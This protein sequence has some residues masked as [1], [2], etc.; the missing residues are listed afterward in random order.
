MAEDG[1]TDHLNDDIGKVEHFADEVPERIGIMSTA[2]L[3]E[4]SIGWCIG[5]A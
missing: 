5:L 2:V 3:H 4:V 1:P